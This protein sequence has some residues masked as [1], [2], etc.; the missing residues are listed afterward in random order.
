MEQEQSCCHRKNLLLSKN[1]VSTNMLVDISNQIL[2]KEK[3]V[4]IPPTPDYEKYFFVGWGFLRRIQMKNGGKRVMFNTIHHIAII[5]S[6]YEKSK[7]F[8][9]DLLGFKVIRENYRKERDDYKIDLAC[10]LQEIELFIIKNA[11]A[12][13]NYPEALGLRHLAFKVESVADTVKEL[14]GKGIETEPVRLDDYTGKKM[15]F[16]HDPDGLPLE[17]HE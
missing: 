17:I 5:G 13:V 16:F 15:T 8:Y 12:R 10:G 7:H 3:G 9:V 4:R 14:N 1:L 11:P 2:S 6:D